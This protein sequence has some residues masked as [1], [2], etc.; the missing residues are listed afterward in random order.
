MIM[1]W[2]MLSVWLIF[3]FSAISHLIKESKTNR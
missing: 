3:G 2:I 1:F